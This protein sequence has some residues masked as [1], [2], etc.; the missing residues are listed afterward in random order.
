MLLIYKNIAAQ[1]TKNFKFVYIYIH[2]HI[3]I[4]IYIYTYIHIYIYINQS[5][6]NNER[7]FPL[8]ISLR[9]W[10]NSL[11]LSSYCMKMKHLRM[12]QKTV[13]K[14]AIMTKKT[15][16]CW[17]RRGLKII[18]L[19]QQFGYFSKTF[20]WLHDKSDM[21]TSRKLVKKFQRPKFLK[22]MFK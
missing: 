20:S 8:N 9:L 15:W 10:L 7:K 21:Q 17:K 11:L 2:I 1:K 3:H 6:V 13:R 5:K 19:N 4:Y 22:D 16:N 12:G 14:L 18:F